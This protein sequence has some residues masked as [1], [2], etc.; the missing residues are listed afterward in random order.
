MT[1]LTARSSATLAGAASHTSNLSAI[2]TV[3][4]AGMPRM[5]SPGRRLSNPVQVGLAAARNRYDDE[6]GDVVVV[7]L[8]EARPERRHARDGGLDDKLPLVVG[9]HLPLPAISRFHLRHYVD[10]GGEP[11]IDQH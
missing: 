1:R 3:H 7:E 6:L 4:R 11:L 8:V 9:L 2:A 5:I 10:A